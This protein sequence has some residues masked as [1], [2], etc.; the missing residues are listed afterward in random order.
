MH[1]VVSLLDHKYYQPVED[2]LADLV[3]EFAVIDNYM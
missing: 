3:R 2:L 1:G